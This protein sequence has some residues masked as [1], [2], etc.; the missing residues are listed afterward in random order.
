MRTRAVNH[1]RLLAQGPR[2]RS[3]REQRLGTGHIADDAMTKPVGAGIA[4]LSG[5]LRDRAPRSTPRHKGRAHA[6]SV[7]ALLGAALL[8]FVG[9]PAAAWGSVLPRQALLENGTFAE[10]DQTNAAGST[11]ANVTTRA[12]EGSHSAHAAYLGG[13]SNGYSRGIWNV[14]WQ[15]GDDVWYG[16][17]FYLPV[18]FKAAMQGQVD[19]VRWDNWATDPTTTEKSGVVIFRSDQRAHLVRIKQG[20]E[21]VHLGSAFDLPEGR[22]FWLE[23]HQQLSSTG[24]I[25]QVY[26]DGNLVS[27]AIAQ[28]TYGHQVDRIRYGLVA[29]AAPSQ[30]NPLELWFD[31][32]V[33]STTATGP[34]RVVS[35]PAPDP[36]LPAPPA[37]DTTITSAPPPTTSSTSASFGFTA[38]VPASGFDCRLD[39]ASWKACSSPKRYTRLKLGKH[40]FQARARDTAGSAD[41]TPA[42]WTWKV[43][44]GCGCQLR[45]RAGCGHRRGRRT[46]LRNRRNSGDRCRRSRR[47]AHCRRAQARVVPSPKSIA[48]PAGRAGT[49]DK[50]VAV[51]RCRRR[52]TPRH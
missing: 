5:W 38:S 7:L 20:V 50:A 2:P 37:I 31:R 46:H 1:F 36:A 43:R 48:R 19:L 3:S 32:A 16:A 23:V 39:G 12:Y 9:L 40:R 4:R 27:S 51:A 41:L 17:A 49:T 18:G 25:N 47:R 44:K 45:R 29:T 8:G 22:W 6:G 35:E 21:E 30:T 42:R 33:A 11:L 14:S 13:G 26:L 52:K 28:N 10:F 15:D 24:G 34:Q